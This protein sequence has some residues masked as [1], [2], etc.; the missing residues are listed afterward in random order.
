MP[1]I[2]RKSGSN[3]MVARREVLHAVSW[4]V[5]SNVWSPPTDEY[6]T[7][8]AYIVR[9]EI[10]GMR[11]DDFEISFENN[12]L[13]I[14]GSRTDQQERRAYH[15]MEIRF[16]KFATAIGIPTAV[17]MDKASAEYR[18]GFLTVILPKA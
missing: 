16:G 17:N 6:E 3:L 9:L 4:Q 14:S 13:F 5:R 18:D 7:N 1:T 8:E 15:Q 2:I 11:D 12:S 10:A